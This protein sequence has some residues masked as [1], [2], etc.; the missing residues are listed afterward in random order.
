MEYIIFVIEV[1]LIEAIVMFGA[2]SLV[3]YFD[4]EITHFVDS[5][6]DFLQS[7]RNKKD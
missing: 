5:Y 1:C 2:F 3:T 4:K 7:L 6:T